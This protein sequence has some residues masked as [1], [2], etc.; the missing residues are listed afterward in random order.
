[1]AVGLCQATLHSLVHSLSSLV[2]CHLVFYQTLFMYSSFLVG[3]CEAGSEGQHKGEY[4]LH[5]DTLHNLYTASV[6]VNG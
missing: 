1:M 6:V 2:S 4:T 3:V 5:D